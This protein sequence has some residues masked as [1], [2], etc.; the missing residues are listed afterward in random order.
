MNYFLFSQKVLQQTNIK[1]HRH[2][3]LS[4]KEIHTLL[5]GRIKF[6]LYRKELCFNH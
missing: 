2:S 6:T 1:Q 5:I 3:D 4:E